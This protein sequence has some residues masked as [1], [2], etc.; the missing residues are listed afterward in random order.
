V[1]CGANR[2]WRIEYEA[3][4][5][6]DLIHT[7]FRAADGSTDY[8]FEIHRFRRI[9]LPV[10]FIGVSSVQKLESRLTGC[11][12]RI[13]KP[14]NPAA[15][16][17]KPPSLS[18]LLFTLAAFVA[19]LSFCIHESETDPEL[20]LTLHGKPATATI[21]THNY[22]AVR[23]AR[24]SSGP[25]LRY[26]PVL[27]FSPAPGSSITT[28]DQLSDESPAG[29]PGDQVEILYHPQKPTL[30]MRASSHRFQRPAI[31]LA[32]LLGL[33]G[34]LLNGLRRRYLHRRR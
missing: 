31:L 4:L 8:I 11:G 18:R 12:V 30:V 21:V 17:D 27:Q 26:Y 15:L 34:Y 22:T 7:L 19:M 29:Q 25:V 9:Q 2:G 28:T 32:I 10:G 3:P 1:F 5:S 20:M 16:A 14:E 13:P 33:L 6:R 24:I 23:E